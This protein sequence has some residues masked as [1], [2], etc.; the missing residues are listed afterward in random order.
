MDRQVIDSNSFNTLFVNLVLSILYQ[1]VQKSDFT[2][3]PSIPW[4]YPF[5]FSLKT[6]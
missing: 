3:M 2:Q 4:C 6:Y 5:H 1:P